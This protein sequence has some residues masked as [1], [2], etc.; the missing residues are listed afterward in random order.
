MTQCND[1]NNA[2]YRARGATSGT[3]DFSQSE[4]FVD[5][6]EADQRSTVSSDV[7]VIMK[8]RVTLITPI[9][10]QIVGDTGLTLT[11]NAAQPVITEYVP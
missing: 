4:F 1:P 3:L 9:I 7:N 5:P 11:T 10:S 8:H 2:A 6:P